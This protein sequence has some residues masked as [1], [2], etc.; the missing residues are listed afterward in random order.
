M[1]L[2]RAGVC[3]RLLLPAAAF[4]V[5]RVSSQ[6]YDHIVSSLLSVTRHH[7]DSQ[8][9]DFWVHGE[10]LAN[11]TGRKRGIVGD[12]GPAPRQTIAY[13]RARHEGLSPAYHPCLRGFRTA[14][15]STG[16]AQWC[17]CS[18]RVRG[19]TKVTKTLAGVRDVKL[20]PPA[21][22]ALQRQR[23]YTELLGGEI[24]QDAR[25]NARWSG[26]QALRLG[27]RRRALRAAD[28]TMVNLN[29]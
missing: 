12:H 14:P 16:S 27:P 29:Y 25:T 4:V 1:R 23:T 7:L 9:H 15:T 26:D 3:P 28:Q 2:S 11:L 13:Q 24:F 17:A 8:M 10:L 18:E 6:H 19:E 20:L 21:F 22:E 5:R